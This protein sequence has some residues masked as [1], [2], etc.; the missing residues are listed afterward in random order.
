MHSFLFVYSFDDAYR[1]S[2]GKEGRQTSHARKWKWKGNGHL[3]AGK[4]QKKSH[5]VSKAKDS[6]GVSQYCVQFCIVKHDFSRTIH[7]FQGHKNSCLC[8]FLKYRVYDV[9]MLFTTALVG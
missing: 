9:M 6:W 8:V 7:L 3:M 4:F 2:E 1:A 5:L